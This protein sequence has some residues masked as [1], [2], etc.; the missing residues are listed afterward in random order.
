MV[1]SGRL[2]AELKRLRNR[3]DAD[4]RE[5]HADSAQRAAI[6]AEWREALR[7]QAH[8]RHFRRLLRRGGRSGRR[9]LDFGARLHPLPRRQRAYRSPDHRRAGRADGSSPSFASASIS[10]RGRRTATPNTCLRHS[11]RSPGFPGSRACTTRRTIRS[12]AFRF[13]RR[14]DRAVRLLSAACARTAATS[15]S[16]S[17]TRSGT[18]A[19][20]ATSTRTSPRRPASAT[21]SCRRPSSSR[22]GSCRGRSIRRSASSA[23]RPCA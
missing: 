13:R 12:S 3:L 20:S 23:T 10:A 22:A 11:A 7:G 16:T 8:R 18:R 4:L 19:S 17:P 1:D 6:E 14:R 9:A 5:R 15:N 2:L 21:R